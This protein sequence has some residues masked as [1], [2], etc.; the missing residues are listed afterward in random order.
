MDYVSNV[1]ETV[2]LAIKQPVFACHVIRLSF[3][4]QLRRHAL[5]PLI[6]TYFRT[7]AFQL[8]IR[9]HA[10]KIVVPALAPKETVRLAIQHLH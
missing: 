4:T 9:L 7:R 2:Q 6:Q 8:V 3:T 1:Q 5:V 10:C